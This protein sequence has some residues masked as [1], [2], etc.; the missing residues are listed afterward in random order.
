MAA[1]VPRIAL[2][3]AMQGSIPPT[4]LA[5]SKVWPEANCQNIVDDSLSIDVGQ[6]GLDESMDNRFLSLAGYARSC[7]VDGVL[8]TCSAFGSSIEKV[9]FAHRDIPVLKPN[10]AMM[11]QAVT[12]GGKIG[13]SSTVVQ[14]GTC[15]SQPSSLFTA[16]GVIC[17]RAH[18][19]FHRERA[20]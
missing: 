12:I 17:F 8:F 19:S 20:A 18:G 16:T 13:V 4:A 5:F 10:E 6:T 14:V 11:E 3:H 7:N 15:H 2:V 9:K 1:R